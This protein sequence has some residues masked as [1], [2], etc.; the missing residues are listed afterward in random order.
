[1]F[2]L[3]MLVFFNDDIVAPVIVFRAVYY[4]L[5]LSIAGTL[6]VIHEVAIHRE[7]LGRLFGR[8]KSGKPK[9]PANDSTPQAGSGE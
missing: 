4:L 3:V 9:E 8:R 7:A 6:M 5:P 2:E 1:V